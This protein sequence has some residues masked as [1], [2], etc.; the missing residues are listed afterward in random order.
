M[1]DNRTDAGERLAALLTEREIEADIV[2]AVPRGGL[3][4][5]RAVADRLAVPLDIVSA[6]KIG[7]PWNAELAVGA[8]AS[9][10][11]V[12]LNDALIDQAGID[13]DYIDD[14]R[15]RERAAARQRVDSYRGDRPPLDLDGKRVV[16]VDDGIA[17]GATMRA[18][19]RQIAAAG[20][21]RIVLAVPVAP[22]DTLEQLEAC[23]DELVCVEAPADFGAVGRFYRAFDQ[24]T[25]EQARSYLTTDDT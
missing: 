9:D 18:C 10:G 14:Q 21:D 4:A 24:V 13:D 6:R 15:E 8:V 22:P 3:P 25:D 20:A 11:S 19:L 7:A 23:V 17:T 1:F 12:W 5:G 2:L 16:V